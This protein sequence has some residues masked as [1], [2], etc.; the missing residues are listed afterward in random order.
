MVEGSG[1]APG[2]DRGNSWS[3]AE[4]CCL[5]SVWSEVEILRRL[6]SAR[7][8]DAYFKIQERLR[9]AG[10]ANPSQQENHLPPKI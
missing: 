3:Y 6:G 8:R 10:W 4:V 1:P 5:I 2:P 7:N 9:E